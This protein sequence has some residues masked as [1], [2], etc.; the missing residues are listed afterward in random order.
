MPRILLI[1]LPVL[2]LVVFLSY[3][4][5]Q[6]RAFFTSD[7]FV[8]ANGWDEEFYLSRQGIIAFQDRP[9]YFPLHL[10]LALH[11]L[12][13]SA[14]QQNLIF[15]SI[16]PPVT[17]FLA[18]LTLKHL[19]VDTIR[20]IA[21]ATLIC[22]GSVLF[23][24]ASPLFR[25]IL[26]HT[27][28]ATV[29]FM[30]GWEVYPSILRTPN[31]EIPFFLVACAVYG[32]A[33]FNRWWVLLLPLPMLYY[34]TAV[35]YAFIVVLAFS[36][37]LLRSKYIPKSMHALLVA[38]VL[39][40]TGMLAGHVALSWLQGL[41]QPDHIWRTDASFLSE[42]RRPQIPAG[43]I[44]MAIVFFSGIR[45]GWMRIE[46][47]MVAPIGIL[48]IAS[49]GTANIHLASGFMLSQ[50]NYYDY[51]LSIVFALLVAIAIESIPVHVI[52]NAT[53]AA[54]LVMVALLSHNSQ[55][56]WFQNGMQLSRELAPDIERLRADPTHAIIPKAELSAQVAFS[57]PLLLFPPISYSYVYPGM[58]DQCKQL[59][60]LVKNALAFA[61][62]H[63]S[64][65]SAELKELQKWATSIKGNSERYW[66]VKPDQSYCRDAGL[67]KDDF[68]FA[69]PGVPKP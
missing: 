56:H 34:H 69:G 24:A 7:V 12:G 13:L 67:E 40:M 28:N 57:T 36:Y 1:A 10:N 32:F 59:P 16:L 30:A 44:A 25:A 39:T 54:V 45:L 4:V 22:F 26:G 14:A 42:T 51:G 3:L 63:L 9:G 49:L 17:A 6:W 55:R 41:Y 53:L 43:L 58:L 48:A 65:D 52:R 21:Y 20:A 27:R 66:Q 62:N 35:A 33:R 23:N 15:D 60:M 38:S 50:K 19:K 64:A 18:F 11:H 47:R 29:W 2:S 46:A 61:T 5:P 68:Y 8:F 31:P 37:N